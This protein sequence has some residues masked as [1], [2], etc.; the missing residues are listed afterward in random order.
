MINDCSSYDACRIFPERRN[1]YLKKWKRKAS[2][3]PIKLDIWEPT[4]SRPDFFGTYLAVNPFGTRLGAQSHQI[5]KET[6]RASLTTT[7]AF[8]GRQVSHNRRTITFQLIFQILL[9][10]FASFHSLF[11][12]KLFW[13]DWKKSVIVLWIMRGLE[14]IGWIWLL[15]EAMVW[16]RLCSPWHYQAYWTGL[17]WCDSQLIA[18]EDRKDLEEKGQKE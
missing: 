17:T 5:W 4:I 6:Y 13:A 9:L 2:S 1:K 10:M 18:S 16:L 8:E 15:A 14:R 7:K 11:R 12:I 3:N